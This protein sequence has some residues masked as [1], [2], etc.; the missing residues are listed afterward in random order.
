[1]AKK[2]SLN[3]IKREKEKKSVVVER[4]EGTTYAEMLRELK[5]D[6]NMEEV[7]VRGITKTR[8]GDMIVRVKKEENE[9]KIIERLEAVRQMRKSKVKSL[10]KMR[11]NEEVVVKNLNAVVSREEVKEVICKESG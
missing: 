11:D 9:E 6:V 2:K 10:R 3:K 8:R 5:K 1:M 4:K 7:D